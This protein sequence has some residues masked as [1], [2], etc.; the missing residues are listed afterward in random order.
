MERITSALSKLGL[1]VHSHAEAKDHDE[2]AQKLSKEG[3]IVAKMALLKDKKGHVYLAI[4]HPSTEV[5]TKLLSTRLG[6]GKGGLAEASVPLTREVFGSSSLITLTCVLECTHEVGVLLDQELR[7]EFWVGAANGDAAG[8]IFLDGV[9]LS[10]LLED[11]A[12]VTIDFTAS[13]K[14]DRENPPDLKAFADALDPLPKEM[15]DRTQEQASKGDER[16]KPDSTLKKDRGNATG[17]D[18][19]DGHRRVLDVNTL[20]TELIKEI[21]TAPAGDAEAQRRVK[22]DVASRLNQLRNA[23][24]AAG[25]AAKC[26]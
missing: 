19:K 15:L 8:S 6:C 10:Q 26:S 9:H 12:L 13:P 16:K 3:Q 4:H 11:R 24:Y 1:A 5:S 2:H 17:D 25:F 21:L 14:I 18:K 22:L 7:S 23:A 20:T